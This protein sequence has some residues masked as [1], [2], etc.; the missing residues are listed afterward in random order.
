MSNE[1]NKFKELVNKL[2]TPEQKAEFKKFMGENPAFTAPTTAPSTTPA[3]FGQGKLK[4]GT[5]VKYDTETLAVGSTVMVVT[6]EGQE[7]PAP[8][9]EHALEDGTVIVVDETGKVLEVKAVTPEAVEPVVQEQAA[10]NPLVDA[11]RQ[12][13]EGKF[14]AANKEI[15]NSKKEVETLKLTVAEQAKHLDAFRT[16]FSSLIELP[17]EAA[18]S[19]PEE[20]VSKK[21]NKV[22]SF[23]N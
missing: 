4:D 3:V 7:L 20:F 15:E 22:L 2:L 18:S 11:L 5:V 8:A 9:G 19:K 10:T 13:M 6:A 21:K 14:E 1:G 17:T 23:I 12:L 16:F